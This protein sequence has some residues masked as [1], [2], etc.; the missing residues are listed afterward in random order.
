MTCTMKLYS[1]NYFFSNP[2]DADAAGWCSGRS[3]RNEDA[4]SGAASSE[5][6]GRGGRGRDEDI[7]RVSTL[8]SHRV[9]R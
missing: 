1:L 8:N 3:C 5:D 9:V 6:I 4:S 7:G 2:G